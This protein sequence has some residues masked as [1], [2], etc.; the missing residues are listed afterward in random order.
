MCAKRYIDF[1]HETKL[2]N[3]LEAGLHIVLPHDMV[4]D[5]QYEGFSPFLCRHGFFNELL[6]K[7]PCT[8]YDLCHKAMS[9]TVGP[10]ARG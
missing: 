3:Q 5:F 8:R 4:L 9:S 6:Q 10:V 2:K 1:K 7:Q